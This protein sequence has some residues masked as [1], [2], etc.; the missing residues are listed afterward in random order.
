M[1]PPHFK[2]PPWASGAHFPV[3]SAGGCLGVMVR[4]RGNAASRRKSH[5]LPAAVT[6]LGWAAVAAANPQNGQVVGG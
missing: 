1:R 4:G 5:L 2:V 3:L 6:L